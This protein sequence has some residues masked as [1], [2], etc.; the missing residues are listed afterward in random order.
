MKYL[1]A[2]LAIAFVTGCAYDGPMI[3]V[4]AGFNGISA[5][6]TLGGGVP[7]PAPVV[8]LPQPTGK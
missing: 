7:T 8:K 3:T 5:G 4:S 6:V 2:I 1:L